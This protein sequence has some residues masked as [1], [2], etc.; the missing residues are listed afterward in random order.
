MTLKPDLNL[1]VFPLAL[2]QRVLKRRF[3]RL[4]WAFSTCFKVRSLGGLPPS[5]TEAVG[6]FIESFAKGKGQRSSATK[7]GR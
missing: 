5:T 3:Q 6:T 7:M 4:F 1:D 2:L